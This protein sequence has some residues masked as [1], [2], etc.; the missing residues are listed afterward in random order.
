[1]NH[2]FV[3]AFDKMLHT[4]AVTHPYS[5]AVMPSGCAYGVLRG[6]DS[7]SLQ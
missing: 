5:P 2:F 7:L 3:K 6:C 4:P 1:M